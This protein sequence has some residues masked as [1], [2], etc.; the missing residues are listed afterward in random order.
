V[1]NI[2]LAANVSQSFESFLQTNYLDLVN[3][4][5]EQELSTLELNFKIISK[6]EM[7]CSS[8]FWHGDN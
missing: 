4:E 3:I 5:T 7:D 2:L 1:N 8:W 6:F